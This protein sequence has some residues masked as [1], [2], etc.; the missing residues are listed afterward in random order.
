MDRRWVFDETGSF[1]QLDLLYLA[2]VSVS[3]PQLTCFSQ[4][5]MVNELKVWMN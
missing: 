3:L 2:V 1:I 5:L 4:I